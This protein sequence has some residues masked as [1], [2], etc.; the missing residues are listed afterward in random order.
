MR[1]KCNKLEAKIVKLETKQN[2]LAQYG[3]RNN[4]VISGIPDSIDDNNLENTA[5]SMVSNINV[6]IEENDIKLCHRFG[7][8]DATSKSK[9]TIVRFVNRKNCNKIFENKKKL[10]E[11]NNGKH[12]FREGTKIFVSE[13]L[14][15]MN[16]SIAFNCRKLK[17][18]KIIIHSCYSRNGIINIERTD[19][20]R[21][22]KV[23]HMERLVNLFSDFDS[24]AGEMYLDTS[25]DTDTSVHSTY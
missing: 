7:K 19:K 8:P 20:R 23:F 2:S 18:K 6:N 14:T 12:N 4:T 1:Q 3:R 13:S 15:P 22:V 24:E 21:P 11:N 10:N 9:K 5:I 16:E 17:R 25:Q